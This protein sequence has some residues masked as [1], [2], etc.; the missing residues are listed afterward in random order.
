[1]ANW[2]DEL[3]EDTEDDLNEVFLET[4]MP[5]DEFIEDV[6]TN[7]IKPLLDRIGDW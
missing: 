1:M 6:K 2:F 4:K 5:L 3:I 7:F